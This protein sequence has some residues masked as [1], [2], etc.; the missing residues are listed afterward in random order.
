VC[1]AC[2]TEVVLLLKLGENKV[3]CNPQNMYTGRCRQRH[4]YIVVKRPVYIVAELPRC[5]VFYWVLIGFYWFYC[6]I[7]FLIFLIDSQGVAQSWSEEYKCLQIK[8]CYFF[9]R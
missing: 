8:C 1:V 7:D 9:K 3:C 2:V 4:V 5:P 6:S